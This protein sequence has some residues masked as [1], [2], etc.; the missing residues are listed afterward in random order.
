MIISTFSSPSLPRRSSLWRQCRRSFGNE[1]D[2][3]SWRW[4]VFLARFPPAASI[5]PHWETA[6]TMCKIEDDSAA[7]PAKKKDKWKHTNKHENIRMYFS[8]IE[9]QSE[10]PWKQYRFVKL[11]LYVCVCLFI[12]VSNL[13]LDGWR[14]LFVFDESLLR[15][16][17]IVISGSLFNSDSVVMIFGLTSRS[18]PTGRNMRKLLADDL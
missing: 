1:L 6:A 14:S 17:A 9:L 11:R 10:I 12:C 4:R 16:G 13:S 2:T 15:E 8:R 5:P 18:Q 7:P 3:W